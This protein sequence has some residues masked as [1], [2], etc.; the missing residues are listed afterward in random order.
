MTDRRSYVNG[1]G[2]PILAATEAF[3][4][5]TGPWGQPPRAEEIV[6]AEMWAGHE[7]KLHRGEKKGG[8]GR[9]CI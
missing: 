6:E 3:V 7:G 9:A 8:R 5:D 1:E 2:K 4:D